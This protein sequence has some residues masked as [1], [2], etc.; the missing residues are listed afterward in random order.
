[1]GS[2]NPFLAFREE[3][4]GSTYAYAELQVL[5]LKPDERS[6]IHNS[7]YISGDLYPYIRR[8]K[9]HHEWIARV[10]WENPDISDEDLIAML[11]AQCV[12]FLYH[13]NG[14]NIIR[15]LFERRT[16][17]DPKDWF[18]P[19]VRSMLIFAENTHRGKL[20]LP[21]RCGE[22]FDGS[23]RSLQHA[24]F[25]DFVRTGAEQPLFAWERHYNLVHSGVS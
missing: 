11:N 10:L 16:L 21:S 20:R 18:K 12:L 8:C 17:D 24:T 25:M 9:D 13:M 14:L 4:A 22:D 23:I 19:F 3:L 15:G 5:C 2:P 1:M 6:D 7:P